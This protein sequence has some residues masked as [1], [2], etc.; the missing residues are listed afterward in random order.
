MTITTGK[1]AVLGLSL[2]RRQTS[3]PSMPGII[4]SSST[5][6]GMVLRRSCAS[7]LQPVE[8]GDD[9]EIFGRQLGFEQLDVG[10]DVV[11]DQDARGHRSCLS[12]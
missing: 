6:S 8:G 12:R 4:T 11:D 9:L 10:E 7:A 2:M 5:M 1:C 3:K